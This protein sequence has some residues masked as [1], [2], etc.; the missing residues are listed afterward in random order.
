VHGT[1]AGILVVLTVCAPAVLRAQG[2][3]SHRDVFPRGLT[4]ACGVGSYAVRDEYLTRERYSGSLPSFRA[5]WSRFHEHAGFR[6]GF[7]VRSSDAIRSHAATTVVTHVSL[8][9]DYLYPAGRPSIGGR[10]GYLFVGPA[11]G[12]FFYLNDQQIASQ[13]LDVA[14]SFAALASV[15]VASDL[16]VPL[17]SR[18]QLSASARVDVLSATLRMIDIVES[19]ESPGRILTPFSGT[20]ASARLTARFRLLPRL[21]LAA[22]YGAELL[23]ITPWEKLQAASDEILVALTLGP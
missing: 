15:G 21:S 23:R 10:R 13:G 20:R 17:G 9:L 2:A 1:T 18:V 22:G 12:L 7:A 19:D 4:V 6:L 11:A 8:D 5:S 3:A 14:L 16:I